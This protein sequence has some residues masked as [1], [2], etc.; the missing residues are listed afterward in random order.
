[1]EGSEED[2]GGEKGFREGD[3]PIGAALSACTATRSCMNIPVVECALEP[4]YG[5]GHQ[6]VL[7]NDHEVSGKGTSS[8]APH[9]IPLTDLQR[10]CGKDSLLSHLIRHC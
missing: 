2:I 8:L 10:C 4:L 3:P 9:R 6:S 1:M 7:I 5:G